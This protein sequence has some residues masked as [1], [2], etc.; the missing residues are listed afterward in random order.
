VAIIIILAAFNNLLKSYFMKRKIIFTV[1]FITLVFTACK[2]KDTDT[3]GG[4]QSA[5]GEIGAT[6]STTSTP[7][8]GVS[9]VAA[10]VVSLENGISSFSGS[11]VVTNDTYKNILS[12]YPEAT[13]N[14]N[15]VSISGVEFKIT[16]EGVE[17]VY[18]LEPGI[19]VKYD[20]NVGDTYAVGGGVTRTVV[21]KSTTDD[22][23]W[24]FMEIK[25]IQVEEI[26]NKFGVKKIKYIANHRFGIVGI[27]FT[28]DDNSTAKI[29][30]W[31]SAENK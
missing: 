14:G 19:I 11:A 10:S 25:V 7:V 20:S 27:E 16:T 24:G 6:L 5:L 3:L 2:K 31:S 18:G 26:T 12:N 28:F 29:P 23:A 22:Y 30:I 8:P 9:S 21:S 1:L 4:T 17:A 15:N 13:I